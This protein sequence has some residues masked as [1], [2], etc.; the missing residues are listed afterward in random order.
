MNKEK[1]EEVLH[2]LNTIGYHKTNIVDLLGDEGI[3]NFNEISNFFDEMLNNPQINHRLETI[4]QGKM[5][6]QM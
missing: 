4:Q 3:D 1:L 5:W 2:D 6:P